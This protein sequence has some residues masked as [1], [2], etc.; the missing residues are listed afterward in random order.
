VPF[1]AAHVFLAVPRDVAGQQAAD[2][3]GVLAG[4]GAEM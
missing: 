4:F 1:E 2:L 3:S